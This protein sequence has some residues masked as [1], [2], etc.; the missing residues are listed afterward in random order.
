MP[1]ITTTIWAHEKLKML[2]DEYNKE[3]YPLEA[4]RAKRMTLWQ[5]VEYVIAGYER[6]MYIIEP[7]M[8]DFDKEV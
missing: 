1:G 3:Y 7:G 6:G 2:R 4:D 5:A 8:F